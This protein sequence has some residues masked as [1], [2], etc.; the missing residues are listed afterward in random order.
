MSDAGHRAELVEVIRQ[1]RNR[2]RL[3]LAARG[4]AVVIG[5]T[6]L[7]L[8]LSASGLEALRFSSQAI[9]G[10][11]I[12]ILLLVCALLARWIVVPLRRRVRDGQVALYLEERDPSLQA[13]ILSAV[14]A[15]AAESPDHSPALVDQLVKLAVERCRALDAA[16]AVER[17]ALR[18]HALTIG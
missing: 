5:G 4:A 14:E 6:A 2:W 8:L 13:E 7:A 17:E 3:K 9:I 15:T 11:R 16:R 1:V 18:R 12:A 10:F